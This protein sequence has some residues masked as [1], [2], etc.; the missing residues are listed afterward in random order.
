MYDGIGQTIAVVDG[1]GHRISFAFD[2]AGRQMRVIDAVGNRTT[3]RFDA[4]GRATVRI[5]GRGLRAS[6][7]YNAA[8]WL[9]GQK[10]Q[11]G[12]RATL[13][14]DAA[15]QRTV[16]SDW[17]GRYT[18][19]LDAA[20]RLTRVINPAGIRLSCAY[21]AAGQRAQ[22]DQPTGRFTYQFDKASRISRITNPEAQITSR[23]Y[24]AAGR[25]T[26]QRLANGVRVSSSYDKAG[27]TTRLA[28][29]A[30]GGTTLSSF[31]YL[32]NAVGNRTRV[33]ESNGDRVTWSYDN[34]YQLT[35]ER[36]SGVNAYAISYT[37][38]GVGNRARMV[39]SGSP[40]TYLY[41]SANQLTRSQAA[42][43]ITTNIFDGAGNLA[44]S[45]APG[46]P[47][48]TN[49]W[50]GEN[51]LTRVALPS[52]IV[53]TFT[54]SGDG[55]RAQKQD[56]SGTTKHLWDGQ[57]IV[58]ETD[59]SNIIQA[60]YT[61][62]PGAYG[63]LVSQRRS[64]TT[65]SYLFDGLGSV[66][67]LANSTG[68]ITDTY[69]YDALGQ[70]LLTGAALNPFRYTGYFGYYYDEDINKYYIRARYLDPTSAAFLSRDPVRSCRK[71]LRYMQVGDYIY[72]LNNP[73]NSVDPSGLIPGKGKYRRCCGIQRL[74]A[75]VITVAVAGGKEAEH[76]D[77]DC[78]RARDIF[79]QCCITVLCVGSR[80]VSDAK[81]IEILG[82]PPYLDGFDGDVEA[83]VPTQEE[84]NLTATQ[85][86]YLPGHIYA[87]YVYGI[88]AAKPGQR[89]PYGE[90][91]PPGVFKSPPAPSL[92]VSSNALA[93]T[94]SHELGH[95]LG[96][97][98]HSLI[99]GNLMS[100]DGDEQNVTIEE[101]Q[102]DVV[103]KSK[104][105]SSKNPIVED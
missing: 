102:C 73:V 89:A 14:Y 84:L 87:Y 30:S 46:N 57:S 7:L 90:S 104:L 50:D 79:Q 40:T 6:L 34:A 44:R 15:G 21:D 32:Y 41:D 36:R 97:R 12:T 3:T 19:T 65:W 103:R 68:A 100:E 18:S 25:V 96:L 105:L 88:S 28:N 81:T 17:T 63:S 60:V 8:D 85:K 39:S 4:G 98:K 70:I 1:R 47:R 24:D 13:S 94:F 82:F 55:L 29:I 80:V 78:K 75:S 42:A 91:F 66:R 49:T 5:D 43:G 16:L 99:L 58:L 74:Y 22:L 76:Q 2:A 67:Q 23:A 37:Y 93:Q 72:V 26:V 11:D 59:G 48:T 10:Y 54:Y 62:E 51:R 53:N 83:P 35:V 52:G 27:H 95:V 86:P 71:K 101:D 45:M 20:G 64:T 38:D 69:L 61:L 92:V 9:T 33:I 77:R 31:S 56:S